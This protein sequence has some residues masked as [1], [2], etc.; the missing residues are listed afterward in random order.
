[1]SCM[2]AHHL[3]PVA[4]MPKEGRQVRFE[5]F[6]VLCATCHRLIHRL[7]R[8][9]DLNGLRALVTGVSR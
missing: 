3:E 1:M 2:D 5:D 4:D 9:D 8:P 7:E 6:K